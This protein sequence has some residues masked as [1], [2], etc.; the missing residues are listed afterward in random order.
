MLN[1]IIESILKPLDDYFSANEKETITKLEQEKQE[2]I[3]EKQSLETTLETYQETLE[4][5]EE[6]NQ[7]IEKQLEPFLPSAEETFWNNKYPKTSALYRGRTWGTSKSMIDIDVRLLVTPQDKQ[8]HDILEKNDLY[9]KNKNYEE[10]V[11]KIYN[12]I[13]EKYY[14]YTYDIDNYGVGEYWEFPFELIQKK[15]LSGKVSVDCD[16]WANFQASFYIAAGVP[17]W[18][19]RI[20]IGSCQ[21]GG[22]S[23]VYVHSDVDNKY[24]HLNSTYGNS[25]TKTKISQFPTTNEAETTDK[26]G[27]KDVWFSFNSKYVWSKF[28]SEAKE[29]FKKESQDLFK[30]DKK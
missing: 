21:I 28:T 5:L 15:I 10:G 8:I 30:I 3:T 14:N 6:K 19:V 24:H 20:V 2:L 11:V 22:H 29:S 13:R 25:K 27:I 18:K 26:L 9:I 17:E 23:T 7:E 12:W 1:G 16:S 4:E